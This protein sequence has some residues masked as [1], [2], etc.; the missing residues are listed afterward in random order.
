MHWYSFLYSADSQELAAERESLANA[1]TKLRGI[2]GQLQDEDRLLKD[3]NDSV[4]KRL[5]ELE[6]YQGQLILQEKILRDK[7][8]GYENENNELDSSINELCDELSELELAIKKAQ[9]ELTDLQQATSELGLL[10]D[11][12]KTECQHVQKSTQAEIMKNNNLIKDLKNA[13]YTEKVRNGQI[14]QASGE[15][16]TLKGETDSLGHI[17]SKLGEDL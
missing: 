2:I 12:Y 14:E 4:N 1:S 7:I 6:R 8:Q 10:N 9:D 3:D 15:V 13:E 16:E 17:N 11:K 5:D